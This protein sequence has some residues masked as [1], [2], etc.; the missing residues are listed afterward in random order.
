MFPFHGQLSSSF[1]FLFPLGF[2]FDMIYQLYFG[3]ETDENNFLCTSIQG[4]KLKIGYLLK[5]RGSSE[6]ERT[7]LQPFPI[8]KIENGARF[9]HFIKLL[10]LLAIQLFKISQKKILYPNNYMSIHQGLQI[11]A[12]IGSIFFIF[13]KLLKSLSTQNDTCGCS[14]YM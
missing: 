13:T 1:L 5:W 4:W 3:S 11:G 14:T 8:S 6:L 10:E 2:L 12:F 9:W 7:I